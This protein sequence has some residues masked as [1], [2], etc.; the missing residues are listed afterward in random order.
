M[1]CFAF[2]TTPNRL[3]FSQKKQETEEKRFY[4]SKNKEP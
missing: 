2:P 4:I 3:F 1:F